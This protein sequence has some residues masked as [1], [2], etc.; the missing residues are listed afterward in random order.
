L[1][2][3][4]ERGNGKHVDRVTQERENPVTM[5]FFGEISGDRTQ[6]VAHEFTQTRHK[7][8]NTALA[9]NEPRNGPTTP[10]ASLPVKSAKKFTIPMMRTNWS[11]DLFSI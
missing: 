8:W 6:R 9:P 1:R 5:E 4:R 11:A 2:G 7:P 10:R 3:E